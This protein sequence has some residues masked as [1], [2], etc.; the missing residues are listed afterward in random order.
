VNAALELDGIRRRLMP[1]RADGRAR[2]DLRGEGCRRGCGLEPS[3]AV[4]DSAAGGVPAALAVEQ[5]CVFNGR[6]VRQ[7]DVA[8]KL[9]SWWICSARCRT[10]RIS[11]PPLLPT[12]AWRLEPTGKLD[13][14]TLAHLRAH[15]APVVEFPRN[16]GVVVDGL[17]RGRQPDD[18]GQLAALK[19]KLGVRRVVTLNDDG[20]PVAD[21]CRQLG[22][23]HVHAMLSSGAPHEPG[24]G[25]LGPSLSSF[26]LEMPTF[27]HCRHGPT[28]PAASWRAAVRDRMAVRHGVRRGQG[29]RFQGPLSRTWSTDLPR[30]AD[31]IP[32]ASASAY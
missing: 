31:M 29:F 15:M 30:L 32:R 11:R 6:I 2:L 7:T 5:A 24:W 19:D 28:G 14:S 27:I 18:I 16:F 10:P 13:R 21:W 22:L 25:T 1:G 26:L 20:P 9:G 4:A 17:Y 3:A 23:R 8:R 12:G